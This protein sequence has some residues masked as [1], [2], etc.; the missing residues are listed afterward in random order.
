MYFEKYFFIKKYLKAI[1]KVHV[2]FNE[3]QVKFNMQ[4]LKKLFSHYLQKNYVQL[5]EKGNSIK[6]TLS[7]AA[8]QTYFHK[9]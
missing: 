2:Y 1:S 9:I 3:L 8:I 7:V 5:A 4:S 6:L